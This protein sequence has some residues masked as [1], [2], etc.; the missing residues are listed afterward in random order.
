[1]DTWFAGHRRGFNI[2]VRPRV[3]MQVEVRERVGGEPLVLVKA[4]TSVKGLAQAAG[5]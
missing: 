1:M 2:A 4:E 5:R 3:E